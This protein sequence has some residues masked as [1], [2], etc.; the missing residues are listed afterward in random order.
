ML[1]R[2]PYFFYVAVRLLIRGVVPEEEDDKAYHDGVCLF[3]R[4]FSLTPEL[5]H[6]ALHKNNNADNLARQ[7]AD[8][9]Y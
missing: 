7:Q 9:L 8:I 4:K 6:P 3:H 2:F 1:K 5:L